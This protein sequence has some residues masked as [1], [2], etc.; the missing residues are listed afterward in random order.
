MLL[1]RVEMLL[2]L[3]LARMG[4]LAAR[5]VRFFLPHTGL[6]YEACVLRLYARTG[7]HKAWPLLHGPCALIFR[8]QGLSAQGVL[9][10][11]RARVSLHGAY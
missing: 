9:L 2:L 8:T 4:I 5:P 11:Q 1:T 6:N 3:R 7:E 10:R